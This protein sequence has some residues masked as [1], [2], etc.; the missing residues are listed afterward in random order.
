MGLRSAPG[1]G[2]AL[3]RNFQSV[4]QSVSETRTHTSPQTPSER[5]GRVQPAPSGICL[6]HARP[7]HPL[8]RARS[9]DRPCPHPCCWLELRRLQRVKSGWQGHPCPQCRGREG[10]ALSSLLYLA[11]LPEFFGKELPFDP[12][13]S[14]SPATSRLPPGCGS[15][16]LRGPWG[17][18]GLGGPQAH[19]FL[20]FPLSTASA[21]S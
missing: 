9:P 15:D 17:S 5:A 16:R 1:A 12:Q 3:A 2:R 6:P 7:L 8:S 11:A 10:G 13:Y 14:L 19:P 21:S 18:A 20:P 4:S